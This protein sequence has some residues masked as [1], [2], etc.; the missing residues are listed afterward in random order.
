MNKFKYFIVAFV[1]ICSFSNAQETESKVVPAPVQAEL[2]TSQAVADDHKAEE[3]IE[4]KFA[5]AK[6]DPL[7][8]QIYLAK[9]AKV[10]EVKAV[11]NKNA[12]VANAEAS[13]AGKGELNNDQLPA[14]YGPQQLPQGFQQSEKKPETAPVVKKSVEESFPKIKVLMIS[15]ESAK[16]LIDG[17]QSDVYQ[18]GDIKGLTV[19]RID[20]ELQTITVKSKS[21]KSK[22]FP[23]EDSGPY[24]AS[25]IQ[26]VKKKDD[27]KSK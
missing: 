20:P 16:V 26:P 8:Q 5:E 21:G 4:A 3:Q 9:L 17:N 1:L 22:I 25:T 13:R 19:L 6:K 15:G 14:Q 7:Y 12:A 27:P 23:L 10:K 18:G 24:P 2:D 11:A